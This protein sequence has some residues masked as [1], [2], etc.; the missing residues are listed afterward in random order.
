ML[1]RTWQTA[2]SKRGD[3]RLLAEAGIQPSAKTLKPRRQSNGYSVRLFE[4]GGDSCDTTSL[5]VES[6]PK[7]E[8]F[9]GSLDVKKRLHVFP[10]KDL[11]TYDVR[12]SKRCKDQAGEGQTYSSQIQLILNPIVPLNPQLDRLPREIQNS[13]SLPQNHRNKAI[14]S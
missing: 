5:C 8:P 4:G 14:P 12:A 11:P 2:R 9:F 13:P 3:A 7:I 10:T 6:R 1:H